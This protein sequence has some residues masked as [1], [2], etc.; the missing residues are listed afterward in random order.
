MAC[1]D[2][3][4]R[5]V[6][7]QVHTLHPTVPAVSYSD[8]STNFGLGGVLFLPEEALSLWF[9]TPY[10]PGYPIDLM[11]V[12]AAAVTEAVFGP[13]VQDHSYEEE[14]AFLDNNVSLA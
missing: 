12:D 3:V 13:I 10:P 2:P 9:A 4:P 5:G 6:P 7:D 8:A 1:L 11:E 14:L